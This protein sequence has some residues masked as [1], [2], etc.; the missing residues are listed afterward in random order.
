MT[1]AT[2]AKVRGDYSRDARLAKFMLEMS[3][4]E[5]SQWA[6]T[7]RNEGGRAARDYSNFLQLSSIPLTISQDAIWSISGFR[8]R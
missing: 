8:Q 4:G 6:L 7:D 2:L 5:K 3:E 1:S